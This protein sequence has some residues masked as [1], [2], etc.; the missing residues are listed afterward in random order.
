[1]NMY[2]G[3]YQK[4]KRN[5][6]KP[7]ILIVSLMLLLVAMVGGTVAFLRAASG[8]VTNTFTPGEA[9]ITINEKVTSTSKSDITFTNPDKDG[10]NNSLNTVPV[11]IRATLVIYWTDTFDLSD[12]GVDNP[13][14]QI[15]P[16][17]AGAKI[18]G[19]TVLGTGWF[20]VDDS[21][22][23]YYSEPVAPGS[24]T[25]VMLDTI[26]VTVPDGS[27]AQC[28]ID[29]RA[30]AIQA[31]PENVVMTAWKDVK[32]HVDADGNKLLKAK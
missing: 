20:K 10:D 3:K 8:Q 32:V 16:M 5:K 21:D 4:A 15:I 28:H 31:E 29:V 24:S 6:R 19:G 11:Y 23:Y 17:P 22:I 30:E 27:T 9:K 13:T 12:D 18:E 1:M 14:E 2:R 25:T 26:T 7:I